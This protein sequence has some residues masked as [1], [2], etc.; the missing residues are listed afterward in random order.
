M[1]VSIGRIPDLGLDFIRS[2]HTFGG[3]TCGYWY[4]HVI[5]LCREFTTWKTK[6]QY[7]ALLT[8]VS[9]KNKI[10]KTAAED[11]HKRW[12]NLDIRFSTIPFDAPVMPQILAQDCF[13]PNSESQAILA[14]KLWDEQPWFKQ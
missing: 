2:N 12:P 9:N 3:M 4:D 6:E 14:A 10:L 8:V 11:A 1:M 7:Q 13:H 5:D